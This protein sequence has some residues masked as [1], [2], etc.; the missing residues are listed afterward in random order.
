MVEIQ[1]SFDG[2]KY[3]WSRMLGC[4]SPFGK[5][6]KAECEEVFQNYKPQ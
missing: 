2:S 1:M 3:R 4:S 6:D 5:A